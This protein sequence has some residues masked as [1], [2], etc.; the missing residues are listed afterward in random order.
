MSH[1]RRVVKA[2][3]ERPCGSFRFPTHLTTAPG[4]RRLLLDA[5]S[6]GICPYPLPPRRPVPSGA[7]G[8]RASAEVWVPGS[9]RRKGVRD[10]RKVSAVSWREKAKGRG[11]Q[12]EEGRE[13]EKE[14]GE[15]GERSADRGDRTRRARSRAQLS[16]CRNSPRSPYP[17][18]RAGRVCQSLS[19]FARSRPHRS[20]LSVQVR[21]PATP[22]TPA[23]GSW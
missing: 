20:C 10:A 16:S 15:A 2:R 13:A 14:T 23:S 4:G 21:L 22:Q 6:L 9:G 18:T 12:N 11:A 19:A 1:E 5:R 7:W 8:C 3:P 17:I